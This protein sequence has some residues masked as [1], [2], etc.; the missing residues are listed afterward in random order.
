MRVELTER[1]LEQLAEG[2]ADRLI[3]HQESRLLTTEE[4]AA[5]MGIKPDTL[6]RKAR[7]G[8]I[9]CVKEGGRLMF[10]SE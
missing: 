6:R 10:R 8:E 7:K 1:Q 5:R 4:K 3:R 2:I 9:S